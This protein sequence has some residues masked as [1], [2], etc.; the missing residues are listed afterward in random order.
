MPI[1]TPGQVS[2]LRLSTSEN[3][4]TNV[5]NKYGCNRLVLSRV[6]E[7]VVKVFVRDGIQFVRTFF[8]EST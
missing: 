7:M 1:L 3:I 2:P 6:L 4:L 5:G 8:Q